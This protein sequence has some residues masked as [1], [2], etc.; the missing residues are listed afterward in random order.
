MQQPLTPLVQEVAA[1]LKQSGQRVVFAE[2]CTA[3]LV[4]ASLARV[5]GISEH[6]CGS[7]V[8]YRLDTK[9]KWLEIPAV[10]LNDPGPVSE[11]VASLM[12]ER[13]L[14]LT[15]EADFAVSITGHLGPSAPSDLDGVVYIGVARREAPNGTDFTSV[16]RSVSEGNKGK[17]LMSL[18]SLTLRVSKV[19]AIGEAPPA[20][21][22]ERT[23]VTR[24]QLPLEQKNAPLIPSAY[25]GET[26]REQRQWAA[27]ELVLATVR[28]LFHTSGLAGL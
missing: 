18:P 21:G 22:C 4:A 20:H 3:G 17:R 25:P 23:Q 28:D 11:V 24:H 16:T 19:S 26:L 7:A 27:V 8:V 15:P 1:L 10:L 2:S 6:L 5:P 12:A 14:A 9:S 13:V